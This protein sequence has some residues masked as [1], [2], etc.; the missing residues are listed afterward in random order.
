MSSPKQYAPFLEHLHAVA[1]APSGRRFAV[2]GKRDADV[3]GSRV[4]LFAVGKRS[5]AAAVEVDSS[6]GALLFLPGD[7]LVVGGTSG[8]LSLVDAGEAEPTIQSTA[9]GPGGAVVG[10]GTDATGTSLAVVTETGRVGV[11]R[12]A[13]G[14]LERLGQR[15]L[16]PRP[17]RCVAFDPARPRLVTGG[18][19]GIVR[20]FSLENLETAEVR[21]IPTG[22]GGVRALVLTNDGRVVTGCGDGSLR[23]SY[24]D[25]AADE[26]DR[27]KDAAHE[28][29]VV[30]LALGPALRDEADRELPRRLFSAGADGVIKSWPLESRRKPKTIE[31]GTAPLVGLAWVPATSR[32]KPEAR[33]GSLVAIDTKRSLVVL[34]LDGQSDATDGYDRVR[35]ELAERAEQL[36]ASSPKVREAAITALAALPEDDARLLIER[37]LG[38]DDKAEVRK[39]AADVLGRS[40]SRRARPALRSALGDA[41]EKVRAAAYEALLLR[42]DKD[43]PLPTLRAAV[44]GTHPDL[45]IRAIAALPPLRQRS[46]LVPG[47]IAERLSDRDP[48][49]R[50]AAFE[51]LVALEPK[52]SVEPARVAL[53]RGPADVRTAAVFWLGR[54]RASEGPEGGALVEAALDDDDATVRRMAFCVATSARVV[55]G[56]TLYRLDPEVRE[57]IDAAHKQGPLLLVAPKDATP[58]EDDRAPLF[59]ALN[60]RHADTALRGARGLA[61]LHDPRAT[62]AL[63]QLS[64]EG[65][66]G[67]RRAVVTTLRFAGEAMPADDRIRTR[68]HWLLDDPDASVRTDAFDATAALAAPRGDVGALEVAA[69][70]MQSGQ[71]DMR[72]KAL[73]IVVKYGPTAS[74]T[75]HAKAD[76]LLSAALD[77]ESSKVRVTAYKTLWAWHS[78]TPQPMLERASASRHADTRQMV[79]EELDR[80][81]ASWAE[82]LLLTMIG[83]GNEAVGM[84]AYMA[85]TESRKNKDRAK[86][87]RQRAAVHLA[88]MHSP[89][90]AVRAAGCRGAKHAKDEELAALRNR[91]TDLLEDL[92]V[93]VHEAAIEAFDALFPKDQNAFV[94]AY[95]SKYWTLRVRAAELHGKRRDAAAIGPMAALL[96]LPE[97]DINRPSPRIR[98]RAAAAMADVADP[99]SM[100][101]YVT[102]LDDDDGHVREMGARGLAGAVR[103]GLERP[104]VAALSHD[105]LAVRSWVA[106]GLARLGDVRAVPV[107]A[108]TLAHDHKPIRLGAILSFVALGHDGLR[109]VLQGLEDADREIQDLVFAIVVARD[110]A[111]ARAGLAPDLLTAALAA[112]SPELR[113]AAARALEVRTEADSLDPLL[114]E[115]V[116]PR[117]P[118]R[119]SELAKWPPEDERRAVLSVLVSVL[120]SDD[121][122]TRYAAA[123]VLSLR[124][125]PEAFWREAKRL[126]GPKVAPVGDAPAMA[127][128]AEAPQPRKRSWIR[129]LAA[130]LTTGK[131]PEDLTRRVMEVI[132]YA[133]GPDPKPVPAAATG[134]DQDLEQVVF[135]TYV[136]L[137]RQAPASGSADETHRVRRDALTRLGDLARSPH[138]GR[139]AV[140]PALRRALSDPH[141]LVRKAA[142]TT[143]T[144][145]YP[146]GDTTPA[147]LALQASYADVGRAAVDALVDRALQGDDASRALALRAVDAAAKEVR[148]YAVQKIQQLFEAGSLEPWLVALGSRFADVRL[149]VVARLV[150]AADAR[151]DEAL[152]RALESDHEDLRERA[153]AALAKRGDVRAADVLA[154]FLRHDEARLVRSAIEGLVTLVRA[155]ESE[156]TAAR[157][158]ALLAARLEDDPDKTADVPQLVGAIERVGH[159]DGEAPL[160]RLV[161]GDDMGLGTR[162]FSALLALASHRTEPAR[163][164]PDGRLRRRFDDPLA[165]RYVE[166]ATAHAD[167]QMRAQAVL[168]LRDIDDPKAE[169]ILARLLDDRDETVRVA[170]AEAVSFRAEALPEAG[171]DALAAALRR[172]RRDLV[173]PAAAGMAKRRR[174]EALQPLLLVLEAGEQPERE[175]ALLSLGHLSDPRSLPY[176]ER[177]LD[178]DAELSDEDRA[179]APIAVEALG[180]ML[181]R[182]DEGDDRDRIRKTVETAAAEGSGQVRMRALSGLRWAGDDRSR[183]VIEAVV[184]DPFEDAGLRRHAAT[185]LG[186]LASPDSEAVLAEALSEMDRGVRHAASTALGLVFPQDETRV[187]MA[188]LRSPHADVAEPAASFLARHGDPTS[189]LGRLPHIESPQV[190]QRLRRGLIRR[191]ALPAEAIAGLLRHDAVGSRTD[192]AWLAGAAEDPALADPLTEA[193]RRSA[194]A[195]AST[196]D[197]QRR[198]EEAEAW[199]ASLWALARLEADPAPAREVLAADDPPAAVLAEAAR[200]LGHRA[201]TASLPALRGLLAHASAA[202][203]VAAAQAIANLDAALASEVA[204]SSEVTDGRVAATLADA[205]FERDAAAALSSET[206]RPNVLPRALQKPRGETLRALATTGEGTA[207]LTAIAAL[208]R[209][210]GE[211]ATRTLQG[212]LDAGGGDE[213][214]RK[215]VFRALRRAQRHAAK[216]ASAQEHA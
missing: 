63:L 162:A 95:G 76:A 122:A 20:V 18:D 82:G 33:G 24:L 96:A 140:L 93:P 58:D 206:A 4:H 131:R 115:L 200:V 178:P 155:R 45:R 150:D 36:R 119:A 52:G 16:S 15:S 147:S 94:T 69:V 35:G 7:V 32:A 92:S 89:R 75:N 64:R 202:V 8:T 97:G 83:D 167:P 126:R 11:Y 158:A 170:A 116:G 57:A 43:D 22:E 44:V 172:G 46:A 88:A 159:P 195:W 149:S 41:D 189:L 56:R 120:A 25:G 185:L 187:S 91:L 5:H 164:L 59:A 108:G 143:L 193:A 136:G 31:V 72:A 6:V 48:K 197:P 2:A 125:Q 51:A 23:I 114:E 146:Q 98:Q 153:A 216:A 154:G 117:K 135:G 182:L 19:D 27:S 137:V 174:P 112:S 80:T 123:R 199:R 121:P 139:A 113:F 163:K 103:P 86:A 211:D 213:D 105:D 66:P 54:T 81:E 209:L 179:L 37:A 109:G 60:C 67:L 175:R 100:P 171:L 134:G 10:L 17:L 173:L 107:L 84:A 180:R 40:G 190:R 99:Q 166:R 160:L 90:A 205:A 73:A 30:A 13:A 28:R 138:V 214:L 50:Q 165:L 110:V 70:A 196:R 148:G 104:L 192:G 215:A 129:R 21:E 145:L 111:L 156:E 184:A 38:N 207:R 151:V 74:A 65:D 181:G 132:R 204:L 183:G 201:D 12:V 87:Q 130:T 212:L 42:I 106:E 152:A 34:T 61:L 128:E 127:P 29:P 194:T 85:L 169:A 78:E 141:H 161:E 9:E 142:S 49:V 186:E 118:D 102:L 168:A 208:G 26:E 157:V 55:L 68:L 191:G 39:L 210:G 47:L 177:L 198:S 188:R 176:A 3:Q 133:G 203:R 14:G 101:A 79:V 124:P 53:A 77:D 1:G 71:E 62:G 144:S